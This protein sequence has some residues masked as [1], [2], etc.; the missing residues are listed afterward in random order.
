MKAAIVL[1]VMLIVAGLAWSQ[2]AN[3]PNPTVQAMTPL[4]GQDQP[5]RLADVPGF[6]LSKRNEYVTALMP[7]VEELPGSAK[8]IALMQL[9][10]DCVGY[11]GTGLEADKIAAAID[12]APPGDKAKLV[13]LMF[14]RWGLYPALATKYIDAPGLTPQAQCAADALGILAGRYQPKNLVAGIVAAIDKGTL[15]WKA[16]PLA[17]KLALRRLLAV[18]PVAQHDLYVRSANI[19]MVK[20]RTENLAQASANYQTYL[21]DGVGGTNPLAGVTIPADDAVGTAAASVI[22]AMAAD[23]NIDAKVD[24]LLLQGRNKEAFQAAEAAVGSG[25]LSD[26]VHRLAKVIKAIDG[27]WKRATDYVNLF[28]PAKDGV[29]ITDPIPALKKELGL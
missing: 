26:D 11:S 1:L 19:F 24:L 2:D 4:L 7:T 8:A 9:Y 17:D 15:L 12:A 27:H 3:A 25:D 10:W 21:R 28:Q 18:T 22:T 5:K 16:W 29:T 20:E 6:D 23:L 13:S 14:S